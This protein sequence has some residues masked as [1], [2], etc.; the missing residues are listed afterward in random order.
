MTLPISVHALT[1]G[2]WWAFSGIALDLAGEACDGHMLMAYDGLLDMQ[3]AGL[4][5]EKYYEQRLGP[6]DQTQALMLNI[7]HAQPYVPRAS[8]V[9]IITIMHNI[10][11]M[12]VNWK[13]TLK[14]KRPNG[15]LTRKHLLPFSVILENKTF[16]YRHLL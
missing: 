16:T 5:I 2:V 11:N 1:W 10:W 6:G 12:I 4:P 13:N 3:H 7:G 9:H 8:S 14:F 15:W